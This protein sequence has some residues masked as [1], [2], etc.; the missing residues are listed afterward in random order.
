MRHGY[1]GHRIRVI[2]CPKAP[3]PAVEGV[4]VLDGRAEIELVT[5]DGER[6][7]IMKRYVLKV[8]DLGSVFEETAF[9]KE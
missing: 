4:C 3:V 8:V 7:K 9:E 5:D 6:M 2:F 1:E